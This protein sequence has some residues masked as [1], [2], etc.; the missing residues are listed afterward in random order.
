MEAQ[1]L[2]GDPEP[3]PRPARYHSTSTSSAAAAAAPAPAGA[4]DQKEAAGHAK[5]SAGAGA[6]AGAGGADSDSPWECNICLEPLK[7]TVCTLCGHLYCWPC[8][9]RWLNTGHNSCPVCKAGVSKEN[10][11]PVYVRGNDTD[12]RTRD[13]PSRPSSQR[14][15]PE[16]AAH[17]GMTQGQFGGVNFAAGVGF[18]PSLLGL[19]FQGF[20]TSGQGQG[21]NTADNRP[22]TADEQAQLNT[23][24]FLMILGSLVL[25]C[26]IFF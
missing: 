11:I 21:Q 2:R 12:P 25:I 6:G 13:V 5:P 14:A 15:V 26:L 16:R 17:P 23:S 4:E 3:E 7:D 1:P 22:L 19:Q 10:I 8:L 18:F 20:A 24:R 9:Y